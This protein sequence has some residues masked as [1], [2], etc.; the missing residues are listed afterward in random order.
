MLLKNNPVVNAVGKLPCVSIILTTDPRWNEFRDTQE[1]LKSMIDE[2]KEQLLENY[3]KEKADRLIAKLNQ[4]ISRIDY[5]HL[6]KGLALYVSTTMARLYNLPFSVREKLVVEESFEVRDLLFAATH[7]FNYLV[8]VL[9]HKHARLLYGVNENVV[10]V[11][12]NLPEHV[13]Q[14]SRDVAEKVENY[15]DAADVKEAA[16]GRFLRKVDAELREVINQY[17]LPF[18]VLGVEEVNSSFKNM[19]KNGRHLLASIH[20]NYDHA[21]PAKIY[22]ALLPALQEWQQRKDDTAINLIKAAEN[23]HKLTTGIAEI[24]IF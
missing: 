9:S 5:R 6:P 8:L 10:D 22:E 24:L 20:G 19:T 16:F 7:N 3:S 14:F 11:P 12:S 15:S 21:T 23:D 1:K 2:A 17:G 13:A 18:F 4:L